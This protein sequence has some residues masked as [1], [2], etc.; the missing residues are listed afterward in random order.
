[1][2]KLRPLGTVLLD[3]ETIIAEMVEGHDLQFGDV[4]ALVYAH[5]EVHHPE[6]REEYVDGAPPP[7]LFY[8][9][10]PPGRGDDE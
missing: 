10:V 9:P 2:A 8:G 4:L 5:L 7:R 6:A 1:M 3:L